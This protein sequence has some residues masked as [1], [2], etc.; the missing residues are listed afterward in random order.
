[1]PRGKGL[2]SEQVESR[3]VRV[4]AAR[5][6]LEL[7]TV[8]G[9]AGPAVGSMNIDEEDDITVLSAFTTDGDIT[10]R[11]G[12]GAYYHTPAVDIIVIIFM[13]LAGSKA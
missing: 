10:I 5:A 6:S 7:V 4:V 11:A 8:D 2:V 13:V 1:M 9:V 12:V 3:V